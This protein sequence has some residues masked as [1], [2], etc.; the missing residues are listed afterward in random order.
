VAAEETVL[1]D[2]PT[3]PKPR[4]LVPPGATVEKFSMREL[5]GGTLPSYRQIR[6]TFEREKMQSRDQR[7]MLSQHIQNQLS[8]EEEEEKRFRLR[9]TEEVARLR[10]DTEKVAYAK[11]ET[12]GFTA[13][14]TQAYTEEKARIA[15]LLE[16]LAGAAQV[17]TDAKLQLSDQYEKSVV[18]LAYRMASVIVD[19]EITEKPGQI[20]E[21]IKAILDRIS[22]EDDVRI[23][24]SNREFGAIQEIEKDLETIARSG[25]IHFEMDSNLKNGDCVIESVSGEIASLIDDKFERLREELNRIYPEAVKKRKVGG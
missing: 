5:S 23:R 22:R 12:D 11:G 13:G 8:V 1:S 3:K 15:S 17:L 19:H 4:T 16:G 14:K 10:A 20:A 9:V 21:T 7:F 18:D 24:L 2:K 25:R 6:S